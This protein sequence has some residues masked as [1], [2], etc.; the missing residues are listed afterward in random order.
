MLRALLFVTLTHSFVL[1][2]NNA[3]AQ[4]YQQPLGAAEYTAPFIA[5]GFRALFTCSAHFVAGRPLDDIEK[6]ELLDTHAAD[7]PRPVIDSKHFLVRASDGNGHTRIAAFRPHM[8]CT[9][10]PP[11][12]TE[13]DIAKLA[14]IAA[15]SKANI[16]N[17]PFPMGEQVNI[18]VNAK[19]EDLLDNAFD[20][21]TFGDGNIATGI[22]IL[23]GQQLLAERYRPGFGVHQGYRTWST[24][25]SISASLLGIAVGDGLI[26]LDQP[27]P[28]AA[29]QYPDDPRAAI[30]WNHL[31]W[32]SSGLDSR[33]ADTNAVYF[34]GQDA[35]SG[36]TQSILLEK[37][38]SHWK[39]ANND[40][41]LYLIGLRTLLNNDRQYWQ[42]PYK[43]LLHK[44]GMYHTFMEM[45]HLGNFIGSSQV[46]STTRDLARFGLLYLQDGVWEGEQILPQGWRNFVSTAAPSRPEQEGKQGYG[47]QFWLLGTLPGIPDDAFT[48]AGNKG[49]LATVIPSENLV[50]V[51]TGVDPAGKRW[52]QDKFVVEVLKALR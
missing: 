7:L 32:M 33:G 5:A 36:A 40:T 42:F 18:T 30:T 20:G 14:G 6:I 11:Q 39:Y 26:D 47:A 45:D 28:I 8:G 52:Q 37:P 1:L 12:Y 38:G 13:A 16:S 51:R 10:L 44:I 17:T 19:L 48:S 3:R 31:L 15:P 43:R 24:A 25:K 21:K 9:L 27:V 34:G 49:Q 29:W 41:L 23:R 4:P 46:Y 50:I 35:E 2:S 22:V